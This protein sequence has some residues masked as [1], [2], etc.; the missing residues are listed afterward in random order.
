[1]IHTL[2]QQQPLWTPGTVH[3]YHAVTYGW[4]AGELVRRTD[5]KKR[6]LGQFIKDEIASR[7]QIEFYI[8]LPPEIQYRVS[9]VV[10][11]PD[12]KKILNE[13]ML[14]LFTVW[15]DPGIHQAEIPAA[16]GITNAWSIARLYASLIGDLDDGPEQRLLTDEILK[17][18]TMSN[19][20][21][22]EMDLVLQYHSS[23]GMGFHQFDQAL[24]AFAPGTFGH[25]G[26]GGSI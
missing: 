18:A 14:T 20:P 7:T 26:A 6:S 10:P 8:G 2:E 1:M 15:N 5:P 9:P 25:H 22:N 12:V 23:F 13:T 11:Y 3:G 17:R 24:P 21:L 16:I 19:T 4:L